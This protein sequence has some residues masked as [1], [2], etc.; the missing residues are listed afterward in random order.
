VNPYE[1]ARERLELAN[2]AHR[3]IRILK[4][5]LEDAETAAEAEWAAATRNLRLYETTPSIPLPEFR[6]VAQA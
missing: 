5:L 3:E 2:Q 6:K 1:E 4:V